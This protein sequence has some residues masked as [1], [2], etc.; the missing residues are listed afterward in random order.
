MYIPSTLLQTT[1]L[2]LLSYVRHMFP[3][4]YYITTLAV[5]ITSVTGTFIC[6]WSH[7]SYVSPLVLP[8]A[9]FLFLT[10]FDFL[11][12]VIIIS[13]TSMLSCV[14]A[15]PVTELYSF[16]LRDFLCSN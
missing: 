3:L 5:L 2:Y 13:R 15:F 10:F 12:E 11:E 8:A 6:G 9:K 7:M 4:S 16:E 14:I 1:I